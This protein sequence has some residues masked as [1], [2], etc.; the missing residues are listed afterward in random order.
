MFIFICLIF[1]DYGFS[2]LFSL[3]YG[4]HRVSS[5]KYH[6]PLAF[7]FDHDHHVCRDQL[8]LDAE[9]ISRFFHL[10]FLQQ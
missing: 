7:E 6:V 5:D 2:D 9:E 3:S 4:A 10:L 8:L 1:T